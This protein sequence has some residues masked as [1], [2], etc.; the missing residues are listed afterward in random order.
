LFAVQGTALVE[1]GSSGSQRAVIGT[2]G[3]P[4]PPSRA[5]L[6]EPQASTLID[7]VADDLSFTDTDINGLAGGANRVLIGG[8]VIQFL[9][10]EPLGARRWRLSGLLRGRGGTEHEAAQGQPAQ[11]LAVLLDDSLV[12]LDPALVP[13]LSTSR[14]AAI[15]TGDNDAVVAPLV[16][17][18]LSRRPLCP[19][20][21]RL[22]IEADETRLFSWTRRARGHYRWE[23]VVEVPLVEERELYRVGYGPVDVP[24]TT[25]SPTEPWL[26]LSMAELVDLQTAFGAD[27][28]WVRQIGTFDQSPALLLAALS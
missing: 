28:L 23:G 26:R 12:P 16:N 14:I 19:V 5:L 13:P 6:L 3:E 11:T 8:E 9:R 4:L 17:A 25:W 27:N 21:P 15:G 10:A 18:G 24:H 7:L 2:L 20:R 1:L 22:R